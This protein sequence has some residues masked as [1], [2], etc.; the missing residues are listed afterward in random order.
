M[1]K[2]KK[3]GVHVTNMGKCTLI[4]WLLILSCLMVYG[5]ILPFNNVLSSI[6]LERDFFI[7][8]PADCRLEDPDE[9]SA[10]YLQQ[11]KNVL[12]TRNLIPSTYSKVLY[13]RYLSNIFDDNYNHCTEQQHKHI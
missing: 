7:P 4:F 10:G 1:D 13:Q 11:E 9:C 8:S 2:N 6:L 3:S 5:C 12:N